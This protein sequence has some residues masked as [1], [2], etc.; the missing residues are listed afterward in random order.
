MFL[1]FSFWLVR[2]VGANALNLKQHIGLQCL[3]VQKQIASFIATQA[4]LQ[5]S[6]D[7]LQSIPGVGPVIAWYVL[8]HTHNFEK[9]KNPRQFACYC[10]VAPFKHQSGSSLRGASKSSPYGN[11]MVKSL[12][13]LGALNAR[14]TDRELR[15]YYDRK[16][17]QKAN[18]SLVMNALTNKLIHRIFA[19]IRRGTPYVIRQV[20]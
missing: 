5:K 19:T 20:Y 6:F 18:H 15:A 12:L 16:M 4:L 10:C 8:L 2:T 11:R 7:L 3:A 13:H 9:H 14:K 1:V 17:V